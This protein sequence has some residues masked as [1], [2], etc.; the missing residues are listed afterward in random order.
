MSGFH[1]PL[2]YFLSQ[3]LLFWVYRMRLVI[4]N[5]DITIYSAYQGGF[6]YCLEGS[7]CYFHFPEKKWELRHISGS[8][9]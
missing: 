2:P 3:R 9:L 1:F 5:W 8:S 4:T 6:F 7:A